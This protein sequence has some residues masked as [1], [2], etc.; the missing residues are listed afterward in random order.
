MKSLFSL[1]SMIMLAFALVLAV[2]WHT[3][4][5]DS[6]QASAIGFAGA[7]N[8]PEGTRFYFCGS[9]TFAAQKPSAR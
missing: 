4:V 7:F 5:I 6:S 9:D 1:R 8:F 3:G 2:L